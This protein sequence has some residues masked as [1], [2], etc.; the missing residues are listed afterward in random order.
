MNYLSDFVEVC[1]LLS[2]KLGVLAVVFEHLVVV[3]VA[4]LFFIQ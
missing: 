1:L 4:A 3:G 2:D